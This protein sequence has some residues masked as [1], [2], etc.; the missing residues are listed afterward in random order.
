M[1]TDGSETQFQQVNTPKPWRVA[2]F[3]N[4]NQEFNKKFFKNSPVRKYGFYTL[5]A[6][7]RAPPDA[8]QESTKKVSQKR[9]PRLDESEKRDFQGGY[10]VRKMGREHQKAFW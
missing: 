9:A 8:F 6:S 1:T 2:L 7:R 4:P 3:H 5:L 10:F